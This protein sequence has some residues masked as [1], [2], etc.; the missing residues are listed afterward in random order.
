MLFLVHAIYT[1]VFES[2]Y[3]DEFTE[4]QFLYGQRY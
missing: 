1:Y 4:V 3:L 2:L